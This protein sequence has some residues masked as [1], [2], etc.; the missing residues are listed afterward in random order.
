MPRRTVADTH[1]DSA[2][3]S[4]RSER[5]Q[6]DSSRARSRPDQTRVEPR[7]AR[8]EPPPRTR[9]S[10]DRSRGRAPDRAPGAGAVGSLLPA[11]VA[12]A[13]VRPARARPAA[14]GAPGRAGDVH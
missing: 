6:L 3:W 9:R 7:A 4:K 11:M 1:T 13:G 2:W 12:A 10:V 14:R 8:A 5:S